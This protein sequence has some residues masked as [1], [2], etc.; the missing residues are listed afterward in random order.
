MGGARQKERWRWRSH[1]RA[2]MQLQLRLH[3]T[4]I[5][6]TKMDAYSLLRELTRRQ[7]R[8]RALDECAARLCKVVH[9]DAVAAQRRALRDHCRD[10]WAGRP[11]GER[12][13]I[14]RKER[15]EIG[16]AHV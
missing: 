5:N 10:R 7:Q 6:T 1:A 14:A 8:P 11:G 2:H 3:R 13:Q 16:R 12:Q 9:D 4:P 15:T